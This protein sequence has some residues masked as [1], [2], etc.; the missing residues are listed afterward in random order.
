MIWVVDERCR[1]RVFE[2][3]AYTEQR[4]YHRTMILDGVC[5]S[6]IYFIR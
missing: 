6:D 3:I 1:Y 5:Y 2:Y 4:E